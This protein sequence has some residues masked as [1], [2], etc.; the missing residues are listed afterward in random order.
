M[1]TDFEP[2]PPHDADVE[3]LVWSML[4]DRISVDEFQRLEE[5]LRAD[6]DARRLYLECVRLHVDLQQWFN[7]KVDL[8]RALG[9]FRRWTYRCPTGILHWPILRYRIHGHSCPCRLTRR[10]VLLRLEPVP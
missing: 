1:T 8:A 9:L 10:N 3:D 4:D 6:E 7:P 2:A 5:L